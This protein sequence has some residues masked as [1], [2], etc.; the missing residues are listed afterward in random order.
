MD[1][2]FEHLA[3]LSV[4]LEHKLPHGFLDEIRGKIYYSCVKHRPNGY[5]PQLR[6]HLKK[7]EFYETSTRGDKLYLQ[8]ADVKGRTCT[9]EL[10]LGQLWTSD[11]D[12]GIVWYLHKC[13]LI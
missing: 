8:E 5:K 12:Y 1:Y 10:E 11:T 2:F 6:V 7:T 3:D 9:V 13:N 4:K